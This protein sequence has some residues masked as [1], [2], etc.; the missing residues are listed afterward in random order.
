MPRP[1]PARSHVNACAQAILGLAVSAAVAC[2]D[3]G[4]TGD[5]LFERL[6]PATTG[7]TFE[8]TLAESD[9]I[10]IVL[11]E[12]LYNGGGVGVGDFDGNG[13]PD[14]VFAGNRVA[15]EVYLQR[16]PW[17]FTEVELPGTAGV[18]AAGVSVQDV[19]G[20]GRDDIYLSTL[21]IDGAFDTPN[22][23]FVNQGPSADGLVAFA[24]QAAQY[25]LAD[26]GYCTQAAWLDVDLDGDLDLYV[27]R[28]S[29]EDL[30]RNAPRGPNNSGRAPSVDR[31]YVNDGPGAAPRFRL[32]T[33]LRTEGW[34]LG[35][36]VS[37]VNGDH[38]P[39]LY[40]ANDFLSNDELLINDGLGGFGDSL[41]AYTP[42]TSFNSMGVDIADLSGDAAS[43][44]MV[45]DMLPDDNL[46]RKTM[47][48]DIPY[49][50]EAARRGKRLRTSVRPQ[51]TPPS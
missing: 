30:P 24:E 42:H 25:G 5:P 2:N 38:Y 16:E 18:W 31:L 27:L 10:N 34:G 4:T 29:L 17:V 43:E 44:I 32:D 40:I 1:R 11:V 7:I 21:N 9:S 50:M 22:L 14:L 45:V 26:P 23:M 3:G 12:Y 8:N 41:L 35:V 6:A 51:H 20:D 36:A 13:L 33:S 28:N 48:G 37:D 46:R 49:A 47:F 15:S 39:D 19:N